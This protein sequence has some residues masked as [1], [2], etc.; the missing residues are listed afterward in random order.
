M[1]RILDNG[2]DTRNLNCNYL[3]FH[4]D[5][6]G[7]RYYRVAVLR[8][9]HSLSIDRQ[10][11]EEGMLGKQWGALRG[12]YNSKTDFLYA[13]L[14]IFSP[15]W[16][17]GVSQWYGAAANGS[18]QRIAAEKAMQHAQAVSATL[19]ANQQAE[20]IEPSLDLLTWYLNFMTHSQPL[21]ILG[22]PDPRVKRHSQRSLEGI[23][24][25]E[26]NDDLSIEQNEILFRGMAALQ[27]SFV[28][29]I[30]SQ[31]ISRSLLTHQMKTVAGITS[32][33]ASRQRGVRSMSLNFSIPVIA[34]A[35]NS[36]GMNAGRGINQGE[37][38]SHTDSESIG[39]SQGESYSESYGHSSSI[40]GS[41]SFGESISHSESNGYTFTEGETQSWSHSES[42]G[43]GNAVGS[44][45][46]ES[47]G[48]A[49]SVGAGLNAGVGANAGVTANIG[50]SKNESATE[51]H[52][53]SSGGSVVNS[54]NWSETNT[55]GGSK[56]QSAS[57][58][59]SETD[60][61]TESHSLS[62]SWAN[63]ESYS[64]TNG[65]SQGTSQQAGQADSVGKLE[66]PPIY[67]PVTMIVAGHNGGT[68]GNK[69]KI[70]PRRNCHQIK[71]SRSVAQSRKD[72]RPSL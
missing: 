55:V 1:I 63:T 35:G 42:V 65:V 50:M 57:I 48:A 25:G 11:K 68:N 69:K 15:E 33:Y 22:H 52:G 59:H 62:R 14:G 54:S 13:A 5:E 8:E 26:A 21:I 70:Y 44:S 53:I 43:G 27:K 23:L 16:Y 17:V 19:Y 37:S 3:W 72:D 47:H 24:S 60:T 12:I 41:E 38:F 66:C 56:M 49:Y 45:W 18:T 64:E 51:S 9:L 32:D 61:V 36:V 6:N 10:L 67:D 2:I 58:S 46:G 31:Y 7:E 34:N 40:G 30:N 4:V 39:Q 71:R 20:V 28:F 29:Q